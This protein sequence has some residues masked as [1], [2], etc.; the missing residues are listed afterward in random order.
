M[1]P[2]NSQQPVTGPYPE[3]HE[4]SPQPQ[5]RISLRS[6]FLARRLFPSGILTKILYASVNFSTYSTCPAH[7][8]R[9]DLITVVILSGEYKLRSSSAF[10]FLQLR[11]TSLSFPNILLSTVFSNAL[12][13]CS[14]FRARDRISRGKIIVLYTSSFTF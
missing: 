13:L 12:N 3:S 1:V 2:E 6:I 10:K 9:L 14:S 7:L 8:I 5:R 4:P 11:V